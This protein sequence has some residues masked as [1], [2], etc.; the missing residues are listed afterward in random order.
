M[1]VLCSLQPKRKGWQGALRAGAPLSRTSPPCDILQHVKRVGISECTLRRHGSDPNI[2]V[3]CESQ[4]GEGLA[5]GA[6]AVTAPCLSPL[7]G[8]KEHNSLT[9]RP[10]LQPATRV[11]H[12]VQERKVFAKVVD[13]IGCC[14]MSQG[15]EHPAGGAPALT[16]PFSPSW[17]QV[18]QQPHSST[19]STASYARRA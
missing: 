4:R 16:P 15:G 6:P 17:L 5:D 9:P 19:R 7:L 13:T 2:Y 12:G 14:E 8:G 10:G 11:A 18:A 1:K 3:L